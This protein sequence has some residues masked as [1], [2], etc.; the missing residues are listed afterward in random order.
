MKRQESGV[1]ANGSW[2]SS[3]PDGA[4]ALGPCGVQFMLNGAGLLRTCLEVVL[5]KEKIIQRPQDY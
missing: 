5:L 2:E 1:N 3:G 4:S